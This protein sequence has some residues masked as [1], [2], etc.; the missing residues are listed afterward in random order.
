VCNIYSGGIFPSHRTV[1][2]THHRIT[3]R[4]FAAQFAQIA[5]AIT[6]R[7]AFEDMCLKGWVQPP[8][9]TGHSQG[10]FSALDAVVLPN[11][12]PVDIVV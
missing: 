3:T 12:S 1:T 9:F 8:A 2:P 6:P 10:D 7:A 5:L 11:S 4:L